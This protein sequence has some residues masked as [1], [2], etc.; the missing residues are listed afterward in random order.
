MIPEEDRER[1]VTSL[2]SGNLEKNHASHEIDSK[3]RRPGS[4]SMLTR[5]VSLVSHV[6]ARDVDRRPHDSPSAPSSPFRPLLLFLSMI[7]R[8]GVPFRATKRVPGRGRSRYTCRAPPDSG[9][10]C[11]I[12]ISLP[13]EFERVTF[14]E[15]SGRLS[16]LE[17]GVSDIKNGVGNL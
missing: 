14:R 17:E 12:F 3:R 4:T 9:A 1:T 11:I 13:L 6:F 10:P 7:G 5:R 15:A 8:E 16:N 2:L